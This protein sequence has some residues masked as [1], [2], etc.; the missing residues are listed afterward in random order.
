MK[1]FSVSALSRYDPPHFV[2]CKVTRW[3]GFNAKRCG[4]FWRHT[5]PLS[6]VINQ[7]FG[8]VSCSSAT[9]ATISVGGAEDERCGKPAVSAGEPLAL[10]DATE[11]DD[12]G[13]AAVAGPAGGGCSGAA[14]EVGGAGA[15]VAAGAVTGATLGGAAAA[16]AATVVAAPAATVDADGRGAGV[17]AVATVDGG[18]TGAGAGAV[19]TTAG[20]G[21]ASEAGRLAAFAVSTWRS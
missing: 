21:A 20:C 14:A 17:G 7:A 18:G 13:A 12:V 5:W 16:T 19:V 2:P 15:S 1:P 3:P 10:V 9:V 11:P 6:S 4:M 8:R